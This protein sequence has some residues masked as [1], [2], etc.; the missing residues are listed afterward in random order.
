MAVV[1]G[2]DIAS[3]ALKYQGAGYTYGG[4]AKKRGDW[5][6]SSFVSKVL[7]QDLGLA[8]PGGRW[9]GPGMPPNSH[10]PVVLAYATWKGAK[11]LPKGTKP[12]AGDLC[13]WS[14]AGPNGHIGIAT[15]ATHMIS[16]L[17]SELGTVATPIAGNGP[18]GA[19]LSYRRLINVQSAAIP[20]GPGPSDQNPVLLI[21]LAA[22]APVVIAGVI[23]VGALA[24]G[25]IGAIVASAVAGAVASRFYDDEE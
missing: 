5:D 21:L 8:L 2:A 3:D 23:V 25:T 16:A 22:A 24:V 1:T 6:C 17:D 20:A 12:V 7:G 14:G 18:V 9:G 13:V 10:G 11:T 4:T 19:P 15:S